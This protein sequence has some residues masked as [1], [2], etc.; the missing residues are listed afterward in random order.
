MT[1]RKNKAILIPKVMKDFMQDMGPEEKTLLLL[2]WKHVENK[3]DDP[4][5][6][7]SREVT[8]PRK[9][10]HFDI[11]KPSEF[12]G[13]LTIFGMDIPMFSGGG[14]PNICYTIETPESICT[15]NAL[16]YTQR[17]GKSITLGLH[18]ETIEDLFDLSQG[19]VE[20]QP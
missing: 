11:D 5:W 8:I 6:R 10:I 19:L 9:E 13:N 3:L 17:D 18:E 4:E 16:S 7:K 14:V 12:V 1:I 15:K 2:V 20:Y